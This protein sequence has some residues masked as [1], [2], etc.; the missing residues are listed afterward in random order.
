MAN[1]EKVVQVDSQGKLVPLKMDIW[2]TAGQEIFLAQSMQF[3]RNADVAI[4]VYAIN[5]EFSFTD[6]DRFVNYVNE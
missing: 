5:N 1:S 4:L 6:V 3:Y 2:D